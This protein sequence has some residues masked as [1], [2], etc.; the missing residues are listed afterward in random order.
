MSRPA[1]IAGLYKAYLSERDMGIYALAKRLNDARRRM[2][3][4]INVRWRSKHNGR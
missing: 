3:A 4:V 2:G 1:A